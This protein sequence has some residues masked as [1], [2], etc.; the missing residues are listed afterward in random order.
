MPRD[1]EENHPIKIAD[2]MKV[3]DKARGK[4]VLGTIIGDLHDIGKEIIKSLLISAEFE[5][6]DLGVDVLP[7]RFVEKGK[8]NRSEDHRHLSTTLKINC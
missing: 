5:V 4:I 3:E 7:E 8:R 1:S 6:Y 2:G